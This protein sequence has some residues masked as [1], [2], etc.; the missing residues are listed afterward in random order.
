MFNETLLQTLTASL[1]SNASF[2]IQIIKDFFLWLWTEATPTQVI[3][4]IYLDYT[5][6]KVLPRFF[7]EMINL[8][9]A[10]TEKAKQA[11]GKVFYLKNTMKKVKAGQ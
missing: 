9:K 5:A 3:L 8:I 11:L 2:L 6:G 7:R 4:L 1:S 10:M